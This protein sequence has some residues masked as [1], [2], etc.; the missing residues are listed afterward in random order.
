M[1]KALDIFHFSY[2]SSEFLL[3]YEGKNI[4]FREDFKLCYIYY[5]VHFRIFT[6]IFEVHNS[7]FTQLST[8]IKYVSLYMLNSSALFLN[9]KN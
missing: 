2:I 7:Y 6:C 9:E 3:S 1:D 4:F 5:T 8:K